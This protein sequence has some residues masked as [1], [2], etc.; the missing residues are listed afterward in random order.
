MYFPGPWAGGSVALHVRRALGVLLAF[1]GFFVSAGSASSALGADFGIVPGGFAI[2][3]LDTEGNPETRAG[4]HPDR[5]QVDFALEVEGTGTTPRDLVF[6]LPPGFA[7]SPGAVP[8]CPRE[9]FEAEGE[10]CSPESQVGVFELAFVG[11][12]EAVLPIFQL[13]PAPGELLSFGSKSGFE[14]PLTTELRPGDF[15]ITLKASDLP[16]Q[17]VTEGHVELWGV[18][19]DH[20]EGTTIPRQPFLTTPTRCGTLTFTFRT[21]SWL[22]GAQ[23]QSASA[24]TEA[25]LDGCADLTFSPR[26]NLQFGNP[27]ADSP[28][29]LRIDLSAPSEEDANE[30][31]EAQIKDA[32]IELPAG[33]T[34]S[35]GGARGLV[36]CSDDQLE[37]SSAAPALCPSASKVGTAGFT[38]PVLG[39]ESSGTVYLGEEHPDERLRLFVVATGSGSAVKFVGTLHVDPVTG[40]LTTSLT[41]L[42]QL[43]ISRLSLN[44]DGGP[45]ALLASP[46][47]CGP[48]TSYGRFDSYGGGG[49]VESPSTVAI[50]AR[51]PGSL[52]PGPQPFAPALVA[53]NAPPKAGHPTAFSASLL[54][55][56]GEALPRRFT[57]LLPAGLSAALGNVQ[58]CPDAGVNAGACPVGSRIGAV[59]AKV[60]S[61]PSPI[62]LAGDAY[63]TGP[64]QRAPFGLLMQLRAAIGPFDFGTISFRAGATIDGAT[65]RVS[66]R[67]GQLPEAI[68]GIPVRFRAVELRIDRASVLRNPTSCRASSVDATIEASTG[69]SVQTAS[70]FSVRGCDRLGFRPRFR[71]ALEGRQALRRHGSPGLRVSAR[72][73]NGDKGLRGMKLSLPRALRFDISAL[74]EICS[75]QDAELND[76]PLGARV[77][78]ASAHTV[79]LNRPMRGGIYVVRPKDDGLPD[80]WISLSAMGVQLDLSGQTS[81]R[82]GHVVTK[83]TGL[84]DMPLST[85]QMRMGGGGDGIFS[86]AASPCR[87]GRERQFSSALVVE[88]QGGVRRKSQLPIEMNPE[89]DERP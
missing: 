62:A 77:G 3:M 54:R 84:P 6:E 65:G 67:T 12:Q 29:G 48:V 28:T 44:F 79:L 38:S 9:L 27:V 15:G 58:A 66:V 80:L 68:D 11:G 56:D 46:L 1:S 82:H 14:I 71:I 24:D 55:K 4:S 70:P 23:W 37:I 74:E 13:E 75:R 52:C 83:L 61:G 35:P 36:A 60:G 47:A 87:Q 72:L 18:P 63:V 43:P 39:G 19:A 53:Q 45:G 50:A 64:Y 21:R 51:L 59:L 20:Q 88:G 22:E 73:R 78:V 30:R 5:L 8:E 26:L 34:V 76:C 7:G 16:E 69:A 41:D 81:E 31:V 89:C 85:F 17:A 42:P 86:L 40:R 10:E 2:R 49:Q 57:L 25:P 32:T 33:L